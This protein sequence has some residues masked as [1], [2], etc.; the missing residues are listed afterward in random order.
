[1]ADLPKR[2]LCALN[3]VHVRAALQRQRAAAVDADGAGER[4]GGGARVVEH[5]LAAVADPGRGVTTAAAA[6][7]DI[8]DRCDIDVAEDRHGAAAEVG[9][10]VAAAMSDLRRGA[11]SAA[12]AQ[13]D[14]LVGVDGNVAADRDRG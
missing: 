9:E 8:A 3:E 14:A 2:H 5:G 11:N 7:A 4:A 12:S 13:R 6:E 10:S 1:M